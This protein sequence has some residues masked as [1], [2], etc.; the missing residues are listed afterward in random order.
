MLTLGNVLVY[1][2]YTDIESDSLGISLD[3]IIW[4]SHYLYHKQKIRLNLCSIIQEPCP[5]FEQMNDI[6]ST[7]LTA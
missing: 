4:R 5:H 6:D 2:G 7:P 1:Q 3:N